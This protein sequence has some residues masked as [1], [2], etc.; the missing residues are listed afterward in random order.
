MTSTRWYVL[1]AQATAARGE[2]PR[3]PLR[4]ARARGR[5]WDVHARAAAGRAAMR[6]RRC[7]RIK[8]VLPFSTES[9]RREMRPV[10]TYVRSGQYT[11]LC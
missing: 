6:S 11:P 2:R 5:A 10:T 7:L 4:M 9:L 8:T 3:W 1:Y